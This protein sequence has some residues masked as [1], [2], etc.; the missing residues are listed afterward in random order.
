VKGQ[1]VGGTLPRRFYR[2]D[3]PQSN[4]NKRGRGPRRNDN[5]RLVMGLLKKERQLVMRGRV[6][7]VPTHPPEFTSIPWFQVTVRNVTVISPFGLGDVLRSLRNQLHLTDNQGV[8]IRIES[9]RVWGPL[10]DFSSALSPLRCRFY[11]IGETSTASQ[12]APEYAVLED[13]IDYPDQVR[14]ASCGFE[15]PIAQQSLSLSTSSS[16]GT[17]GIQPFLEVTEPSSLDHIVIY[18]RLWWRPTTGPINSSPS[19]LRDDT[20]EGFTKLSI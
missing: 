10:T 17:S 2:E 19:I 20:I 15:W 18:W 7:K 4:S 16:S 13:V 9:C 1:I 12:F 6:F 5:H 3:M 8:S 11:S 14:R